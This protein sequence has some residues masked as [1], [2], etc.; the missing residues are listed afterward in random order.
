MSTDLF[1]HAIGRSY[2]GVM[3]VRS[4]GPLA[5]AEVDVLRLADLAYPEVGA[6]ASE[7]P[8]GYHHLYRER[9]VGHGE[10]Q[11]RASGS[12]VLRWQ[13]QLRSGFTVNAT[14][15]IVVE[16]ACALLGIGIGRLR[17]KAPVRVV[18]VVDEPRRQG[19]AYGTL[20]G[21]PEAGE[22]LF[23]VEHRADDSVVLVIAAFSKPQT[24]LAKVA[25]PLGRVG[26]LLI[27]A[28]YLRALGKR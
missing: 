3:G 25:G 7:A 10:S 19:F 18:Y 2:D 4:V 16:G 15:D 24:R 14:A 1:G 22:E 17:L 8:D 20:P 21:H 27:T 6:T 26:Q 28:R 13:I 11:F 9:V 5:A 12:D 23:C